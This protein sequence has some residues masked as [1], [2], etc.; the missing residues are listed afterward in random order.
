MYRE[1]AK[2]LPTDFRC[3]CGKNF[4]K[5]KFYTE[6][7]KSCGKVIKCEDCEK[8]FST[9]SSVERHKKT[10]HMKI[11]LVRKAAKC[12]ICNASFT[13]QDSLKKHTKI[14]HA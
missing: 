14:Y 10:V 6:H 5:K 4:K 8:T 13:R 2:S 9:K 12:K 3:E 7:K 1:K 11:K